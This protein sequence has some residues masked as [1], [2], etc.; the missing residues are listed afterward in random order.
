MLV[1]WWLEGCLKSVINVHAI[2]L[3]TS[4]RLGAIGLVSLVEAQQKASLTADEKRYPN[5]QLLGRQGLRCRIQGR[6]GLPGAD[7][8]QVPKTRLSIL[9]RMSGEHESDDRC[10][11]VGTGG[12]C[13]MEM[14]RCSEQRQQASR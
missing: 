3:S 7:L 8:T 6:V 2:C 1:N 14:Q 9:R 11:A 5:L 13:L 10:D 4:Q 12:F